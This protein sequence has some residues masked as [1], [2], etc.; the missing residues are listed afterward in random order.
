MDST[1]DTDAHGCAR[2]GGIRKSYYQAAAQ[3][4]E[5]FYIDK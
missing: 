4:N 5:W 1:A 2:I 3:Q